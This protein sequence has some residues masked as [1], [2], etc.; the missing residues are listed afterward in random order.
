MVVLQKTKIELSCD[1]ATPLL[2]VYLGKNYNSRRY[3]HLYVD[4][5]TFSNSQDMGAT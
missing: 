5:S 4:S 1:P 2:G 3:M